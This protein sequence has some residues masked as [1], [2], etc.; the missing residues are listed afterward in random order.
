MAAFDSEVTPLG[1][2]DVVWDENRTGR[3]R[4]E[5]TAVERWEGLSESIAAN[6]G[7]DEPRNGE[8]CAGKRGLGAC[9]V[10][11]SELFQL[12]EHR[13]IRIEAWETADDRGGIR[14]GE[15]GFDKLENVGDVGEAPEED[16]ELRGEIE[17]RRLLPR[18][19]RKREELFVIVNAAGINERTRVA[20]APG[21]LRLRHFVPHS[22]DRLESVPSLHPEILAFVKRLCHLP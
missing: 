13:G 4:R 1:R 11:V 7:V 16:F 3:E 18:G 21:L 8:V 5:E 12:F 15:N 9:E 20:E 19:V 6:Q 17:G 10:A 2:E 14:G 22:G